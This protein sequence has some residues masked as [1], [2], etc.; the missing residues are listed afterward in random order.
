MTTTAEHL[1]ARQD[2]DLIQRLIAAAE[3]AGVH[4]ADTWVRDNIGALITAPVAGDST[5]SSVH[6]YANNV[7]KT[8]VSALPPRP[9]LDPAAV[10]DS[11]LA[12]AVAEVIA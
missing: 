4:D 7:Y 10:V 6:A 1:A 2:E 12:A 5:I 3:Q 9:G 8:A 11:Y